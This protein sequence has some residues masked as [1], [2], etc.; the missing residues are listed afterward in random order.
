MGLRWNKGQTE[1]YTL[2]RDGISN[3]DIVAKGYSWEL[4]KKVKKAINKGDAPG[5]S[6]KRDREITPGQPLLSAT[7]KTTSVALDP[8]V[9]VRYDS[10][11]Y[12]WGLGDE[13]TLEQFIDEATE[14]VTELAGAAPPGFIRE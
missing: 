14:L 4:V 3:R 11:R 8:I 12:L 1:I 9:A 13:Y 5:D 2:S 10:L 6:P 7:I